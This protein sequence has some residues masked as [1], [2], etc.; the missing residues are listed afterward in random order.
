MNP[1]TIATSFSIQKISKHHFLIRGDERVSDFMDFC[2]IKWSNTYM[3]WLVHQDDEVDLIQMHMEILDVMK[4]ERDENVNKKNRKK[5]TTRK[6]KK[7]EVPKNKKTSIKKLNDYEKIKRN[8]DV[9]DTEDEED[10][11]YIPSSSC[12]DENYDDETYD[13]EDSEETDSEETDSEELEDESDSDES[14]SSDEEETETNKNVYQFYKKGILAFGKMDRKIKN[15]VDAVWNKH[16][17]GFIIRKSYQQK[18]EKYG[19]KEIANEQSIDNQKKPVETKMNTLLPS[20]KKSIEPSTVIVSPICNDTT[21]S[22]VYEERTFAFYK[23]IIHVS[24]PMKDCEETQLD[25]IL[26]PAL[27]GYM[28][29]KNYLQKLIDLGFKERNPSLVEPQAITVNFSQVEKLIL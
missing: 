22:P 15:K 27:N 9:S 23:N 13:S 14:E 6:G 8:I 10:E 26:N 1:L 3:G 21:V 17:G 12:D 19:W 5:N 24:G 11:E 28:V 20:P 25:A 29:T 16:L 18:L 7:V 2:D 4:D